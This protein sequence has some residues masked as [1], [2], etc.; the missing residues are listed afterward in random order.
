MGADVF[1]HGFSEVGAAVEH[2]HEQA[3][4]EDEVPVEEGAGL[5]E[6]IEVVGLGHG[7]GGRSP[8]RLSLPGDLCGGIH[9]G[10]VGFVAFEEFRGELAVSTG[11]GAAGVVF[12]NG[13]AEAGG[14][15]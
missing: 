1:D 11:T 10:E 2:G 9:E 14:F 3:G 15:A 7:V 8:R 4:A 12:E 13:A 6:E 5:A